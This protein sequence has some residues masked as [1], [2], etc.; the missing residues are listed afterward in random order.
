MQKHICLPHH[1]GRNERLLS[2]EAQL[3]AIIKPVQASTVNSSSLNDVFK[4]VATVFQQIMTVLNGAKSKEDRKNGNHKNFI[5][6]HKAKM[7]DI[8]PHPWILDK[9]QVA[10]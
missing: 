8:C 3:T 6:S 2:L 9:I 7:A 10:R 5:K 4:V 1:S